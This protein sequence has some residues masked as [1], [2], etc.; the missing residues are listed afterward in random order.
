ME[1]KQYLL[2]LRRWAWVLIAGLVLGVVGGLIFSRFQRPV[3]R[4]TTMVLVTTGA[5]Q[6]VGD[7]VGNQQQLADTYA[8]L[9]LTQPV[10]QGTSD[11]L[12]Y[13]VRPSQ[14]TVQRV[15]NADLV[16]VNVEDSNPDR[17]ADIANTLVAVFLEQNA[18]LQQS[19]YAESEQSL[20]NQIGRIEEQIA[21]LQQEMTT[22]TE[23]GFDSQ[24]QAVTS[25]IANLQNER[26]TLLTDIDRLRFDYPLIEV[27]DPNTWRMIQ[28]TATPSLAQRQELS[29]K[30]ARLSELESLL[31]LYRQIYVNLSVAG[32]TTQPTSRRTDQIQAALNLY[33]QIY[34]NLLSNYEQIR[35][36]RFQTAP[37]VIQVEQATPPAAPVRPNPILNMG[38][39]AILG[40]LLA[41]GAA[42]VRETTDTTLRSPEDVLDLLQ[43]PVLGYIAEMEDD[44]KEGTHVPY[45][46]QHPRSPVAEAFRSL[47][48]NLQFTE[49]DEP[50]QT[51]LI[52]SQGVAEG[53]TTVAVNLAV[54]MAQM[55]R[56]VIL[57]DADLRRPRVHGELGLTNRTGLSNVLRERIPP[58]KVMQ[59]YR[60]DYLQVITS[61]GLPPNPAEVLSSARMIEV[62]NELTSRADIV[63]LDG[64]PLVFADS[65]A[66]SASVDGVLM[67]VRP[68]KTDA[69][70]AVSIVEQLQRVG[71][72]PIGV[73]MN[74]IKQNASQYYG[75]YKTYNRYRVNGTDG[76]DELP[77]LSE[78]QPVKLK[79]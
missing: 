57:V 50:L 70:A 7:L 43:L 65:V 75:H 30:E 16:T 46:L 48:T 3:Y 4:A 23:E 42:V 47:R 74:W 44:N 73:V 20:Q 24:S 38:F 62:L 22:L 12:G 25:I 69:Q 58:E 6:D 10:L 54:V 36:A 18:S 78:T 59:R 66:L 17:A 35:L 29:G 68:S 28:V 39:G 55:G 15:R 5:G 72:R 19:R 13:N 27:R 64:P 53:K 76:A 45:V 51:L 8:E 1:A 2:L 40:L 9:L 67:V 31:N 56:R 37:N 34:S 32:D 79:K 26:D 52:S 63:I 33:Q 11:R 21:A 61:G 49:L 14:V 77:D 60:S 71:A 41:G